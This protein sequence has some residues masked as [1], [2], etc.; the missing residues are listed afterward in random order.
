MK[1]YIY[2]RF[3]LSVTLVGMAMVGL[4]VVGNLNNGINRAANSVTSTKAVA[5]SASL[6]SNES[7][8]DV[9]QCYV[10]VSSIKSVTVAP[11]ALPPISQSSQL[12]IS[13]EQKNAAPDYVPSGKEP[14]LSAEEMDELIQANNANNALVGE[15][16]RSRENN[17]VV[18]PEQA[19]QRA[20]GADCEGK[21][22]PANTT[23]AVPLVEQ[24]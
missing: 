19:A 21:L 10:D 1:K 18:P 7:A 5:A 6:N 23:N 4:L 17:K 20:P 3:T 16:S 9:S 14:V 2:T 13:D 11:G 8:G 15:A 24:E 22:P 12:D